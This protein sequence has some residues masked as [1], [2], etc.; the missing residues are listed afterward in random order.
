MP[1]AVHGTGAATTTATPTTGDAPLDGTPH[2]GQAVGIQVIDVETN[3]TPRQLHPSSRR[4]AAAVER[5]AGV[6][7]G[8]AVLRT[9]PV[10]LRRAPAG[11]PA[12]CPERVTTSMGA[13][14]M[15]SSPVANGEVM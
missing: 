9:A 14:A 13:V 12:I 15:V 6:D 1:A 7:H 8:Q 5:P 11:H 4:G 3:A 10:L 2:D